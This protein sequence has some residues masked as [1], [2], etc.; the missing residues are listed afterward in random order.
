MPPRGHLTLA[1]NCLDF[2]GPIIVFCSGAKMKY[3]S[4]SWLQC[5]PACPGAITF[6]SPPHI[7]LSLEVIR[8]EKTNLGPKSTHWSH[9]DSTSDTENLTVSATDLRYHFS[10]CTWGMGTFSGQGSN[11]CHS[12]EPSHS[13]GNA[14]SLTHLPTR[15]L[16]KIQFLMN[17]Q[18]WLLALLIKRDYERAARSKDNLQWKVL[19]AW[20]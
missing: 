17:F 20:Y 16:L 15:K 19:T 18:K 4:L 10:G 5:W 12:T 6:P 3:S 14:R 8:K 11:L 9:T 13:H 2:Y 1:G 7:I